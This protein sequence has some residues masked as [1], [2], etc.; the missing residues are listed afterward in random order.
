MCGKEASSSSCTGLHSCDLTHNLTANRACRT[1]NHDHLAFDNASDNRIFGA[2]GFAAEKVF[3]T[4]VVHVRRQRRH[5][6]GVHVELFDLIEHEE[7]YAVAQENVGGSAAHK[8]K[9]SGKEEE[10][11]TLVVLKYFRHRI[12]VERHH[13]DTVDR[14]FDITRC[15]AKQRNR[16]EA[17]FKL[18]L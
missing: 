10:R 7:L 16:V 3:D 5:R 9:L 11:I 4:D 18:T 13:G 15:K 14:G 17:A 6:L 12:G 2:N 1:R 8:F